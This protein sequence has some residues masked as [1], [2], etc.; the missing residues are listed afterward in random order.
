MSA[1]WDKDEFRVDHSSLSE[2]TKEVMATIMLSLPRNKQMQV[3]G[4]V[5]IATATP[6]A[7]HARRLTF[8]RLAYIPGVL[9]L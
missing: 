8:K 6:R 9:S 4:T 1:T 7:F 2:I 5:Y 3:V